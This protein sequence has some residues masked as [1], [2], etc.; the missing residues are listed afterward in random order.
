MKLDKDCPSAVDIVR[1]LA[2]H[3]PDPRL[4]VLVYHLGPQL[5]LGLPLLVLVFL[6]ILD[7]PHHVSR[8]HHLLDAWLGQYV[9]ELWIPPITKVEQL[10]WRIAALVSCVSERSKGLLEV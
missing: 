8:L 2:V 4:G 10:V 3:V 1:H 9:W 6:H 7:N 5:Q